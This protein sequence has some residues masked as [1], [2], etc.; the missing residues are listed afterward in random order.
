[1]KASG[2]GVQVKEYGHLLSPDPRYA[3]KAARISAL[4]KDLFAGVAE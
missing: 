1:M 4:T 3:E 2:C